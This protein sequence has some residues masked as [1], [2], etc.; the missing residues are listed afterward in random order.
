MFLLVW[1]RRRKPQNVEE[2]KV[3]WTKPRLW[4]AISLCIGFILRLYAASVMHFGDMDEIVYVLYVRDLHFGRGFV[5]SVLQR[6]WWGIWGILFNP[7]PAP[8]ALFDSRLNLNPASLLF[9][10]RCLNVLLSSLSLGLLFFIGR[11]LFGE[12]TAILAVAL[13]SVNQFMI[14]GTESHAY[15]ENL[16]IFFFLLSLALIVHSLDSREPNSDF[17]HFLVR[18]PLP[19]RS[20]VDSH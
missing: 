18:S 6:L 19:S 20:P 3:E 16:S 10:S 9:A 11:R 5:Y 12:S 13:H 1:S 7:M 4:L 14:I 8:S 17:A 15:S 2:Y